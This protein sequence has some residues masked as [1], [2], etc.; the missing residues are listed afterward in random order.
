[1]NCVKRIA[2]GALV[3]TLLT[4]ALTGCESKPA[5]DDMAYQ[6]TGIPRDATLMTVNGQKVTTE[7]YLFW[8][9]QSIAMQK[10]YGNLQEDADWETETDGKT[11]AQYVKDDA[12]ETLKYYYVIAS[13]AKE[14]G[15]EAMTEDQS[16]DLND[17]IDSI[18]QTMESQNMTLQ[19]Y[20]DMQAISEQGFRDMMGKLNYAPSNL[21]TK[22]SEDGGP[23]VPT[24]EEMDA[25]LESEGLHQVKHILLSTR[26]ETGETDSSGSPVYEDFSE[27]ETAQVKAKADALVAEIRAADDP[28]A[29]FDEK[30]NELSEDGRDENG[31]LY[32]PDGYLVYEGASFDTDFLTA[33]LALEEGE[34]SDPVKTQFGYHIIMSVDPDTEETRSYFPNYKMNQLVEQWVDEAD[35]KVE[36]DRFDA[37][38]PKDFSEKLTAIQNDYVAQAQA[39]ASASPSVDPSADPSAQV[40]AQPETS[41]TP[42]ESPTPSSES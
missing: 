30:M 24:D 35:V 23:L 7:E 6:L 4:G 10:Q 28:A 14:Y 8:L 1:M 36:S 41:D 31:D 13:K 3:L 19:Q 15:V 2:S 11:A 29:L 32:A 17:Q 42:A 20:L 12:M 22:L 37:I 5:A 33:A 40:S 38:D 39:Q 26:R 21:M 27:A 25:F 18:A 34:I 16:T 9:N